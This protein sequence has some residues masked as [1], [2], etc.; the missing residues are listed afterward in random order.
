MPPCSSLSFRPKL[1]EFDGKAYQHN[2]I[3][4]E[5]AC[6]RL[7]KL[8]DEVGVPVDLMLFS[9]IMIAIVRAQRAGGAEVP[10]L[11]ATLYS[12][13]RDAPGE[14]DMVGLFS[15]WRTYSFCFPAGI[16]L[17]G[18]VLQ[19]REKFRRRDFE[20]FNPF[21]RPEDILFNFLHI[22]AQ[23]RHCL[24]QYRDW[25]F[26]KPRAR[27]Y[28]MQ[29][30]FQ[31]MSFTVEGEEERWW[32]GMKFDYKLHPPWWCRRFHRRMLA[33]FLELMEKPLIEL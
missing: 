14:A 27:G 26:R 21:T 8:Q 12:P 11:H 20:L 22:D 17:L 13:I 16:T 24:R 29:R 6:F 15:D 30:P 5:F 18:T 31:P 3:F 7:R 25:E 9:L 2:I 10:S 33:A 23:P 1:S 28:D 4:D 19:I 32:V